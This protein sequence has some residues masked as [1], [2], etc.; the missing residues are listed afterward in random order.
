MQRIEDGHAKTHKEPENK[1]SRKLFPG[2]GVQDT[3]CTGPEVMK[4]A[5]IL[6]KPVNPEGQDQ[7]NGYKGIY[8]SLNIPDALQERSDLGAV[9]DQDTPEDNI[10]DNIA[11]HGYTSNRINRD[12]RSL[13]D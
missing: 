4:P 8:C 10:R 13:T 12:V 2:K 5:N 1:I 11:Y 9:Y 3:A 7:E 6:L